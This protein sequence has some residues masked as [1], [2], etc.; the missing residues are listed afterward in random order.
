[1]LSENLLKIANAIATIEDLRERTRIVQQ[2]GEVLSENEDF[3]WGA[4]ECECEVFDYR[5]WEQ[6]WDDGHPYGDLSYYDR[7]YD[8][9]HDEEE[10][11]SENF[12]DSEEWEGDWDD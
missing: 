8:E 7:C 3:H 4:W 9:D 5:D 6:D 12:A 11:Y 2:V 1:M 10:D